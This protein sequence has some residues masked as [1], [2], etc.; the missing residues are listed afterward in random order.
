MKTNAGLLKLKGFSTED[1]ELDGFFET[2]ELEDVHGKLEM[3]V[4]SDCIFKIHDLDGSLE[5]NQM[6]RNSIVEIAKDVSFKA[7]NAGRK[8]EFKMFD[9]ITSDESSEDVIELNGMKST[10]SLGELKEE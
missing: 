8:C 4:R 10:L 2:I 1:F 3:D 7:V 6:E 5:I 9:D